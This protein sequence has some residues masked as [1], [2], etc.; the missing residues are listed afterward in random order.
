M[1]NNTVLS[2]K[3]RLD[4]ID[5]LKGLGII[6]V[7]LGHWEDFYRYHEVLFNAC[8]E[9]LYLFH[10]ALFCVC[11]GVV[12]RFRVR[13]W[14]TQQIWL[15]LVA[16]AVWVWFRVVVE[17][18][19]ILY[20]GTPLW[21]TFL[22]PWRHAWYL[23]ALLFWELTVPLLALARDK[24]KWPG[25]LLAM[26]LVLGIG[27]ASGLRELPYGLM[28][29]AGFFPYF[30]FGV[31]FRDDLDALYRYAQ[32]HWWPRLAAGAALLAVYGNWFMRVVNADEFEAVLNSDR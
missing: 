14:L 12:A 24:G 13:K 3:P 28:R 22:L 19:T 6:L 1:D 31:L 16:Q 8:Y 15:Y 30:A 4:Y 26:A 27:W 18:Q 5:A 7:V 17:R 10:M 20:D 9:C 32:R 25:K 23:Y 21:Q 29:V 2:A 11:S